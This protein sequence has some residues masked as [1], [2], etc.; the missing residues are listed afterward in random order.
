M[1]L[2][3]L[4]LVVVALALES[5]AMSA[6]QDIEV[7]NWPD[8]VPCDAVKKNRDGS[9]TQ[10][11]DLMMGTVRMEKNTFG[12]G[13]SAARAWDRKCSGKGA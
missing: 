3:A 9:Y 11:K 10:T 7:K 6:A 8:D 12:K 13:T 4:I 5:G 2:V 1:R